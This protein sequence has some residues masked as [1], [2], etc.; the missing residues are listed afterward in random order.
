MIKSLCS[1][2]CRR[3]LSRATQTDSIVELKKSKKKINHNT[4]EALN[5]KLNKNSIL[6]VLPFLPKSQQQQQQ[7]STIAEEK[8]S[9]VLG[10]VF[11]TFIICWAPFFLMNL[12]LAVC[13]TACLDQPFLS[14]MALWLGY[15]SSTINPIIYTIFNIKFRKSFGKIL[16]CRTSSLKSASTNSSSF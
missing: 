7:S 15:A 5:N 1:R 6:S 13:G 8:A 14:E 2:C 3:Y 11:T 10:V 16:L 9:R 4:T 12:L